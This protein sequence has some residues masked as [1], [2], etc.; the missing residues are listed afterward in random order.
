M[1]E[2]ARGREW[3]LVAST[4]DSKPLV[5]ERVIGPI[6][7]AGFDDV[8]VREVRPGEITIQRETLSHLLNV[9]E[10]YRMD[11]L[12]HRS[13]MRTRELDKA[14]DI[15]LSEMMPEGEK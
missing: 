1:S 15:L 10:D 3:T 9:L 12:E 11:V 13:A 2:H 5:W 7:Y 8:S 14:V 6:P 4:D